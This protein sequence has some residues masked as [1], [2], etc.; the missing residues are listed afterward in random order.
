MRIVF[1]AR[2][3]ASVYAGCYK[4]SFP[5]FCAKAL[6]EFWPSLANRDFPQKVTVSFSKKSNLIPNTELVL[7]RWKL[8]EEGY[9]VVLINGKYVPIYTKLYEFL[10]ANFSPSSPIFVTLYINGKLIERRTICPQL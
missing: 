9:E 2:S 5:A 4:G 1:K 6:A 7:E 10:E 8:D 3:S